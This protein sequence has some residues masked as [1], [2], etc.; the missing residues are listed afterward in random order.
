MDKWQIVY[1]MCNR[2]RQPACFFGILGR[3]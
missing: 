3:S 1:T 2:H